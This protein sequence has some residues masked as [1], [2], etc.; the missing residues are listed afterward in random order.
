M[1][2]SLSA[3]LRLHPGQPS[4]H[5]LLHSGPTHLFGGLPLVCLPRTPYNGGGGKLKGTL[6]VRTFWL[7]VLFPPPSPGLLWSIQWQ[8]LFVH[9]SHGRETIPPI[10]TD[11]SGAYLCWKIEHYSSEH[12]LLFSLLLILLQQAIKGLT[13]TLILACRFNRLFQQWQFS[14]P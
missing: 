5:A 3:R 6:C 12:L 2:W 1:L 13:V 14:S 4:S 10:C 8:Q 7:P 9:G 11:V